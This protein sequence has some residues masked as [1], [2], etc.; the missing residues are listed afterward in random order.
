MTLPG[1]AV[2]YQGSASYMSG[3]YYAALSAVTLTG[4]ARTDIV[5]IAASQIGYR[6]SGS[7]SNLSGTATSGSDHTEYGRWY[8]LQDM[9][10]Q[11]FVSFCASLAGV[12]ETIIPKTASTVTALNFF[13]SAGR[14]YSRATVAAGGYTPQAGDLVY[15][16]FPHNQNITNHVGIVTGYRNGILSTIE[17]NTSAGDGSGDTGYVR[18]KSYSISSTYIVYICSP[19]YPDPPETD[20]VPGVYAVKATALNVRSGPG[21]SYARIGSLANG[22][23]VRVTGFRGGWGQIT[24]DG[25]TGYVSMDYLD[26]RSLLPGGTLYTVTASSLNIRAGAGTSYASVGYLLSGERVT[27]TATSADGSWGLIASANEAGY[28]WVSMHYLAAVPDVPDTPG[29]PETPDTPNSPDTP[30]TP[31]HPGQWIGGRYYLWDGADY[32]PASG[33]VREEAGTVCFENGYRVTGWRHSD[34][35]SVTVTDGVSEQYSTNPEGLYYFL[36]DTGYMVTDESYMLGGYRR[37]FNANHTVKPLDGLQ[38]RYGVLYYYKNGVLQTG[39]QTVNGETY[40]FQASAAVYGQAAS[41]WMVIGGRVYYF[42]ASTSDTPYALKTSGTIGGV[43]YSYDPDDGHILYD[44]FLNCAYANGQH[45]NSPATVTHRDATARY[46]IGGVMQYGW[47]T[48]GGEKYY[49]YLNGSS[50]GSGFLCVTSR[51]IGGV[52]HTF[53]DDGVCTDE[54]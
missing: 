37:E 15:F 52:W 33:F 2:P 38:N 47:I 9:W 50:N 1:F 4:N 34:G 13:R 28:G 45:E 23:E 21:T 36:S 48:V 20:H 18:A 51:T 3:K 11:M 54:T 49:L 40:Y 22:A 29:T 35:S 8:G 42:Y 31:E 16:R 27:V 25:K 30:D 44:G 43:A 39:W 53:R 32:V 10:C 26:F 41:M 46:F 19:D 5:N 12:P 17:G 6:E 7:N 14:A 24:Y